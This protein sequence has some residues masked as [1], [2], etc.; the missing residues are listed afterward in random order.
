MSRRL[1]LRF[2]WPRSRYTLLLEEERTRLLAEV[3]SL[4]LKVERQERALLLGSNSAS[5]HD[6]VRRVEPISPRPQPNP[7]P[8]SFDDYREKW[9][10]HL[11]HKTAV[12]DCTFCQPVEADA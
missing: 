2:S 5:A 6:Y 1:Y 4:R 9:V 8:Q 10:Q 3:E 7:P 12:Q 11:D